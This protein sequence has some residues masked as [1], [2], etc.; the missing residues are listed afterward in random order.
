MNEFLTKKKEAVPGGSDEIPRDKHELRECKQ[1]KPSKVPGGCSR[2][3]YVSNE[4]VVA[5]KIHGS[6]FLIDITDN[7]SGDRC[8]LYEINE[9][10]AFLWENLS[11]EK[12]ADELTKLLKEAIVDDIDYHIIFSDVIEFIRTLTEKKFILEVN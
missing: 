9:T 4:K 2:R 3:M 12:T 6:Y 8:A 10:G 7:Y 5:R 1:H 11:T